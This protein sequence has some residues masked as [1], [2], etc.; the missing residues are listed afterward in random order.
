MKFLFHVIKQ[1]WTVNLKMWTSC[2][3]WTYSL[4]ISK[5]TLTLTSN[6]NILEVYKWNNEEKYNC[7]Y[8]L[9]DWLPNNNSQ[10]SLIRESSH[11]EACLIF[12]GD[13]SNVYLS[14]RK[15]E[16]KGQCKKSYFGKSEKNVMDM[17]YSASYQLEKATNYISHHNWC[18]TKLMKW[19]CLVTQ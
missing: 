14:R 3:I 10:M 15:A 19:N 12:K 8:E 16:D 2:H 7:I 11:V 13:T 1:K 6:T 5:G 18:S 17:V 9:S 4:M